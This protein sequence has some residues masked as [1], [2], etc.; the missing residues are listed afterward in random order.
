ME[1]INSC[2]FRITKIFPGSPLEKHNVATGEFIVGMLEGNYKC[3]KTFAQIVTSVTMLAPKSCVS[4]G[5]CGSN[6]KTRIIKIPVTD[7]KNW[8]S[9]G[10]GLLG[11][12]LGEGWIHKWK[13]S[14]KD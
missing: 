2:I 8:Q 3:I 5:V 11:C 7:L 12:E 9:K 1:D 14:K 4:L 10:K 13:P 6:G